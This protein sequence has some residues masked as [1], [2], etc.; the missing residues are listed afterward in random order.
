MAFT[1][2]GLTGVSY[3]SAEA[4]VKPSVGAS[5][6]STILGLP[7]SGN[8]IWFNFI[9]EGG[10]AYCARGTLGLSIID[11]DPIGSANEVFEERTHRPVAGTEVYWSIRDCVLVGT[12]LVTIS[13]AGTYESTG[14]GVIETWDVSTP[15]STTVQD[16]Y[17]K[18]ANDDFEA[19][20]HLYS[21]IDTDGTYVYVSGQKSGMYVFDISTPTA[22]SLH[23]SLTTGDWETQGLTVHNGYCF[24]ANYDNGIRIVDIATPA[25][26]GAVT[27]R[28]INRPVYNGIHLWIWECV[29]DGDYLYCS[30][31]ASNG[32]KDSVERGLFVLDISDPTTIPTDGSTWIRA[33]IPAED[34][35]VWNDLGDQPYLGLSKLGDYIYLAAG[36]KGVLVWD[37]SNPVSP[38][39]KGKMGSHSDGDNIYAAEAWEDGVNEYLMYG[40]GS[41]INLGSKQ[42]YID[43][44]VK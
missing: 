4:F 1:N 34:Q 29:A 30:C 5:N 44:I 31:N 3:N 20:P 43:E 35:S 23:G 12:T 11:I 6:L 27:D 39:Y 33:Q 8:S 2:R 22:I 41:S 14:I 9:I 28:L 36:D 25:N 13:R 18:N 17:S 42:L 32:N 15:S 21:A 19:L 24:F 16:T 10:Y 37:V 40:D 38:I 7:S 26:P